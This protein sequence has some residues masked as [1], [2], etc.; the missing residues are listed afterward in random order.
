MD[1]GRQ[2]T[3]GAQAPGSYS[4]DAS[5]DVASKLLGPGVLVSSERARSSVGSFSVNVAKPPRATGTGPGSGKPTTQVPFSTLSFTLVVALNFLSFVEYGL[6]MP[7]MDTYLLLL[8]HG[9]RNSVLYSMCMSAFSAG[10]LLGLPVFGALANKLPMRTLM[11]AACVVDA[12]GN[13]L[14]G[15]AGALGVPVLVL[16]GRLISG[17]AAGSGVLGSVYIVLT[18]LPAKR[19]GLMTLLQASLGLAVALGPCLTLLIKAMTFRIS[20]NLS[21]DSETGPGYFCMTLNFMLLALSLALFRSPIPPAQL[22]AAQLQSIAQSVEGHVPP[23]ARLMDG[24]RRG[25]LSV[26]IITYTSFFVYSG[27]DTLVA[28]YTRLELS[29]SPVECSY[30]FATVALLSLVVSLLGKRLSGKGVPDRVLLVGLQVIMVCSEVAMV[31][32]QQKPQHHRWFAVCLLAITVAV[33]PAQIGITSSVLSK[34]VPAATVTQMLSLCMAV[35]TIGRITGPLW[36]GNVTYD[37]AEVHLGMLGMSLI[38]A[39]ALWFDFSAMGVDARAA[40]ARDMSARDMS[41]SRKGPEQDLGAPSS[42]P[43]LADFAEG[44]EWDD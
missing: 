2:V 36:G 21:F 43:L 24:M 39:G 37:H 18:A 1:D 6:V 28:P 27:Y 23:K 8:E 20:H 10:R 34:A 38:G 9:H 33:I 12:I 15:S 14:Y 25:T 19:T 17:I 40:S 32:L 31:G 35:G 13:L 7:S 11:V 42:R 30:W 29:W 3:S 41:T 4:G 26:F 22:A 44:G 5:E 16:V